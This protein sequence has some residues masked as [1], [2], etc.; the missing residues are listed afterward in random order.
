M[1]LMKESKAF[2]DWKLFFGLVFLICFFQTTQAI[3]VT[4]Y[5]READV[6][7]FVNKIG[8]F[9]NPSVAYHYYSYPLCKP[10]D[11]EI[12]RQRQDLADKLDGTLKQTSLYA[13]KY[14]SMIVFLVYAV[15]IV[16]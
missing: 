6:P 13:I 5:D 11:D 10:N 2:Y 14:R 9:S 3:K 12:K 8:P 4:T 16:C 7:V 15:M 1:S